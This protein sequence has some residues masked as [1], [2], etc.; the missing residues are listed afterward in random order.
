MMPDL[1]DTSSLFPWSTLSKLVTRVDPEVLKT[2]SDLTSSLHDV[3]VFPV[4][5]WRSHHFLLKPVKDT[6]QSGECL[7][8]V[9]AAFRQ[10]NLP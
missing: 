8:G 6:A 7:T 4:E 5:W 1:V 9:T 10:A 3:E 2:I